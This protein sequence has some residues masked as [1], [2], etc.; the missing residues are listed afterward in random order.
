MDGLSPVN[1]PMHTMAELLR[2]PDTVVLND[3]LEVAVAG[4]LPQHFHRLGR[5]AT[6]VD[7]VW[8]QA[9]PQHIVARSGL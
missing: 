8:H 5:T 3:G 4:D 2:H 1:L 9:R 6:A 7:R